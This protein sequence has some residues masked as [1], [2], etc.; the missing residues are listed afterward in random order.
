MIHDP[1]MM[2]LCVRK[3]ASAFR[4]Q[5]EWLVLSESQASVAG[6]VGSQRRGNFCRRRRRWKLPG[7]VVGREEEAAGAGRRGRELRAIGDVELQLG[8]TAFILVEIRGGRRPN[9]LLR[10]SEKTPDFTLCET[11]WCCWKTCACDIE[12]SPLKKRFWPLNSSSF[13]GNLLLERDCCAPTIF[14]DKSFPQTLAWLM[15]LNRNFGQ[16][17][18]PGNDGK[19]NILKS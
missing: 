12:F 11:K 14:K 13:Q 3:C 7:V 9:S 6:F 16:F 15:C 19:I 5:A 18:K 8:L 10:C 2:R 17:L 1:W 4:L